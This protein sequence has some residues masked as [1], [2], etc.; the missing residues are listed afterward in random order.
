MSRRLAQIRFVSILFI[1]FAFTL[2]SWAATNSTTVA[3]NASGGATKLGVPVTLT[4]MV[5]DAGGGDP[6]GTNNLTGRIIFFDNAAFLGTATSSGTTTTATASITTPLLSVGLHSITAQYISN[7]VNFTNSPVSAGQDYQ[8]NARGTTTTL[9]ALA[10]VT[11]RTGDSATITVTDENGGGQ[12][13]FVANATYALVQARS[14][15]T[16]T[17]LPDGRILV[18]GGQSGGTVLAAGSAEMFSAGAFAAYTPG[19]GSFA[20]RVGGTATLLQDGTVLIVGGSD[21]VTVLDTAEIFDPAGTGTVTATTGPLQTARMNHTATLLPN[22]KVLITGGAD[23]A[24]TALLT[25]NQVEIYDPTAG[26]FAKVTGDL[27]VAR[28]GHTA[29]LLTSGPNAGAVLLAG[30]GAPSFELYT[31]T[32]ATTGISGGAV[33]WATARAGHTATLLPDGNVLVAGGG[34]TAVNTVELYDAS[35]NTFVDVTVSAHPLA[36]ARTGHT[37]TLL[38]DGTVVLIGGLDATATELSSAEIYTPSYDPQGPVTLLSSPDGILPDDNNNTLVGCGLTLTGTGA[39]TCSTASVT[40][41]HFGNGT[42]KITAHYAA[43]T[44]HATS[45]SAAQTLT[46]NKQAL[47]VNAQ[48]DSKTYDNSTTS[49]LI[50]IVTGTLPGDTVTVTQ[51]FNFKNVLTATTVIPVVTSILDA[52]L[53][54]VSGDYSITLNNALGTITARNITVTVNSGQTKVYGTSDPVLTFAVG[55]LGIAP[56]EV[57]SDAFTGAITRVAGETVAGGPYAI[58]QNTLA[59]TSN[60]NLT[61]FTGSTFAITTA[62]ITPTLTAGNKP[63][64]GTN[65]E[66]DANMSCSF[67]GVLPADA[68][69]VSC[70]ATSGTFATA[71]AGSQLVTAT[72][73]MSGTAAGNY[74]LGAGGTT[75]TSTSATATASIT[76]AVLTPTLT[77]GN[78]P[79]DGTNA[80]PDANMSCSFAGVLPADAANVS[81]AATSGTFATANA[82]S[83]LVTATVTMSGTAAGNYTLGAGGTTTST[84]TTTATATASITTLTIA[85][86]LTAGNKPYDGTNTEPNANMSCSLS[87]VLPADALNVSCTATSGTFATANVGSQLVTATVTIGGTAGGNY[88]FG[89]PGTSTASTTATATAAITTL[90]L[91][92][93]LTA[94]NKPYDGTNTEPNANMSCSLSGVLPADALN[95]SCTATSGTF[96]TAN[97]GS[98]LVTATV[99]ISGTAAGNYTLGAAGTSTASTTATATA[100]ITTLAVTTTLTAANKT[101][102]RTNTEPNAN[103]SCT[104]AGVLPADALNVSCTPSLGTFAGTT[105]GSYTVTA[106]AT[107][108]GTAGGNYT[109][110]APGSTVAS[111]TATATASI[112]ALVLTG[113]I[114]ASNKPYDGTAT[115]TIATRTLSGVLSPDIVTYVGGTATFSDKNIGTGKLV[116]ATGLSLSGADAGNYSVNTT[117][118]TTANITSINLTITGAVANNKPYDA[119]TTATV[120]FTGASLVGVAPTGT[121]NVTINSTGYSATFADKLIGNAKPVTVVGVVLGGT[122]AGNYTL[123]QPSGL[124]ANITGVVLVASITASNK[125]YDATT[126]ASFTCALTG[127]KAGDVVTCTGGTATFSDKNIGTGK[128]VTA[129]GLTITGADAGNYT[130]NSTATTTANIST[131]AITPTLTAANKTYD[132]TTTEPNANMSC[133]LAVIFA[134]DVANVSCTPSSGTFATANAGSQTVTATVTIGGTAGGNYTFGATGTATAS[135]TATATASIIKAH[136]TVTAD[137]KTRLYLAP[138]PVFTATLSGFVNGQTL[139]TSGVTGT[140]ACTTSAILASTVAGSPYPIT[141][142][143]GTLLAANYD[144]TPFVAGTLTITSSAT[145]TL[146]ASAMTVANNTGAGGTFTLKA[147]VVSVLTT[148]IPTGSVTFRDNGT[149]LAG[150]P[151]TLNAAGVATLS[152]ITFT[153]SATP[154][155]ITADYTPLDTNYTASTI[156]DN[157]TVQ[158]SSK[159]APPLPVPFTAGT[160]EAPIVSVKY[161]GSLTTSGTLSSTDLICELRSAVVAVIPTQ[162]SCT[163]SLASPLS[164]GGTGNLT[165]TIHTTAGTV[166]ALRPPDNPA[167]SSFRALYALSF[168]MPAIVFLGLAAPLST[169]RKKKSLRGKVV[170]WLGLMLVLG[171]LLVSLGCGG[172]SFVN[173]DNL[174]AQGS[175]NRTLAGNYTAVVTYNDKTVTTVPAP[176]PGNEVLATVTFSVN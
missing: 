109:F 146:L 148:G 107:L 5:T 32:G 63:Y 56:G 120:N 23:F 67:A 86:T 24:G 157:I 101:Y 1:L 77:A 31:V 118:T 92:P 173:S 168:G 69:N 151:V 61:T 142:T 105:V 122:D 33:A 91:T 159:L 132:G 38:S 49:S 4:A 13:T 137:N 57:A 48:A 111:T 134:S 97:V 82:G 79:Y 96:A 17:L 140:A 29:T 81:C 46:I 65:T 154:H 42:Y 102:D 95:V 40:P 93:T 130:V 145:V 45:D 11:V 9:S 100:S 149:I 80:E 78:K 10:P 141:C 167:G 20:K 160:A 147:T 164:A 104:L 19:T 172:G 75:T 30:G 133:S 70:A 66:P 73:T 7:T 25:P 126:A 26:T 131:L 28:A 34:A 128:T 35:T 14:G 3:V 27:A 68:A 129:T 71:N 94:G 103:M 117:A 152:S 144:F 116:T 155:A 176:I 18:V 60:Y 119:N 139:A 143:L 76:T 156:T 161:S 166:G 54:D 150:S 174:G 62:P 12:G 99:T 112:T 127:V 74:T 44:N 98:Q 158:E 153:T 123:S 53:N 114:T 64:D 22:G 113:S 108:G 59:A 89:A 84:T 175:I 106:T 47:V 88:T 36:T 55:G 37:A 90:A 58:T 169:L 50:P 170:A 138:D 43:T 163:A 41:K 2:T 125:V 15:H 135:T 87:G 136:L 171:L 21:G 72:V 115:A 121:E 165:I 124:T 8:V 52:A 83:Q 51:S 6:A 16:A 110:G 85:P 162:T 39:T